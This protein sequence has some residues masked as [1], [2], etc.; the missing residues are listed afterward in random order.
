M[1]RELSARVRSVIQRPAVARVARWLV[2]SIWLV[3]GLY[4]KLLGGSPRHLQIVQSTP[5]LEGATGEHVLAAIGAGEVIIALWVLSGYA[6]RL[7]AAAQTVCLLSMNVVELTFARHL[8][9]WPSLLLP[10]NLAFLALAWVAALTPG[11]GLRT[12]LRRHPLA[13]H[14]HF[15]ECITLTYA[16]PADVLRPLVPPGLEIETL[17]GHAFVAVALV[18]TRALRPEPLPDVLGQDFFLAGYRV[19]TTFRRPDGRRLRGLRILRSDA[20]RTRMVVGGNLLTHYNY[21]R[22]DASIEQV[23]GATR[24]SVRTRDRAGDL[25]LVAGAAATALPP[26]SP[27]MSIHEARFFAGP[28]PFTFEYEPE[29][30]AI[31]AIEARRTTWRPDAIDVR[32]NRVSFFDRP[33]FN[34]VT[35]VLAA[36]FR[37]AD[38]DYQWK[39]GQRYPLAPEVAA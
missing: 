33:P 9:L 25:D 28:L 34:G 30:H 20:D 36:A 16:V 17:R 7:G 12:I 15:T 3:H 38:I 10:G 21:R 6:P 29:T 24:V 26:G 13:V 14:A 27:F 37:V 5:G 18:Q 8:L 35:P 22:C 32:V 23:P 31:I 19:F 39:R 4:H 11:G 2:A 1:V